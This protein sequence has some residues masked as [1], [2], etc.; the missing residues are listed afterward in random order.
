MHRRG[1]RRAILMHWSVAGRSGPAQCRKCAIGW[2]RTAWGFGSIPAWAGILSRGKFAE[3]GCKVKTDLAAIAAGPHA[4]EVESSGTAPAKLPAVLSGTGGDWR[5]CQQIWARA[6]RTTYS[7]TSEQHQ[8]GVRAHGVLSRT[9]WPAWAISE[10]KRKPPLTQKS[11]DPCR[12][13]Q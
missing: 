8:H 3:G 10:T 6:R 1:S 12:L 11:S 2:S 9:S 5:C 4:L 13:F 7:V